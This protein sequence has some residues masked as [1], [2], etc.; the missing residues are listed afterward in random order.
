MNYAPVFHPGATDI[1]AAATIAL[2]LS[3][4]R[5]GVDIAMQ[6]VPT[7][8]ISGTITAPSGA[9]PPIRSSVGLVPAGAQTEMLTG[10]GLRGLST[11]P[12]ADGTYTFTGVAPGTYT[13]KAIVGGG[14]RGAAP[15]APTQ[16]AAADVN[17]SGQDLEIPLTLQPGVAINGRVVFEGSPPTAAELQ[18][19]SFA[20]MPPGSGG[21]AL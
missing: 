2:G 1:R 15:N 20:L 12:G 6:L 21:T 7:A 17:V 18:T 16:W 9:L 14:A 19:L 10:A 4:E 3:E 5:T 13:I 11:Q 8:T